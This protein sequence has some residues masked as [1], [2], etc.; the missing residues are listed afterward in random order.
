MPPR[1]LIHP[2]AE[3]TLHTARE[4]EIPFWFQSTPLR[5]GRRTASH[6]SPSITGFNPRP[7]ARGD[8]ASPRTALRCSSFQS[9]PLREGRPTPYTPNHKL[10]HVSIH[11]PARG[12]TKGLCY[13]PH[14]DRCFNPRPCARGDSHRFE[15]TKFIDSFQSTPLREGRPRPG[16]NAEIAV[17]SIHA[18]ARGATLLSDEAW[19]DDHL[20]QS[21]PL[22]E[23]RLHCIVAL[24]P[25]S[26]QFQS[27]PLREG[28]LGIYALQCRAASCFNPRPCARGDYAMRHTVCGRSQF[29]STPL[30]EGRLYNI[31]ING[32]PDTVSI[33]APARGATH[34]IA[35]QLNL[36]I[37]FNPR[38][39]ARG[40]VYS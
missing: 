31:A 37:G 38:P 18:P 20:F 22:R 23:G 15:L 1:I 10:R 3:G 29:Q 36:L 34:S 21:T 16:V 19:H 24:I 26:W 13:I 11:A 9:T 25:L 39:C 4:F 12:A 27:T 28:R 35:L 30:R 32:V 5:E 6:N 14:R 40:D 33:H 2:P 7:C 8:P 17:V